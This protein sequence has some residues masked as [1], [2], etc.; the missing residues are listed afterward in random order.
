[1][2]APEKPPGTPPAPNPS[3]RVA[4]TGVRRSPREGGRRFD[5]LFTTIDA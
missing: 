3:G 4:V 5:E 2:H 1:M